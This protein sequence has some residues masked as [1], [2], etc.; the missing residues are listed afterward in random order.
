MVKKT[1]LFLALAVLAAA[2]NA[3]AATI[4]VESK[5]AG[6]ESTVVVPVIVGSVGALNVEGGT[7]VVKYD[8]T[9]LT[10][11]GIEAGEAIS[12]AFPAQYPEDITLY[13]NDAVQRDASVAGIVKLAFFMPPKAPPAPQMLLQDGALARLTFKVKSGASGSAYL[14]LNEPVSWGTQTLKT[15]LAAGPDMIT[16]A[17]SNGAITITGASRA[18]GDVDGSGSVDID[19]VQSA[20]DYVMT[21]RGPDQAGIAAANVRDCGST[22]VDIDDVQ[23]LYEHVMTGAAI[24][25]YGS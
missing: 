11:E 14:T 15:E 2:L 6:P 12:Y 5:E 13:V 22:G 7:L 9:K 20:Y 24:G 16:P 8:S 19:D 1:F 17:F 23:L 25:C 10:C 18:C 3:Q 4:S 21:G